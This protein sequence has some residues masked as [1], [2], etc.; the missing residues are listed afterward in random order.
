MIVEQDAV[1]KMPDDWPAAVGYPPWIAEVWM[2]YL[3]NGIKYSGNHRKGIPPTLIL[4]ADVIETSSVDGRKQV[5]FWIKDN[6]PGLS[7]DEIK[8]LFTP[9]ERLHNV[10][11][12]GHGLGLSIVQRIVQKLDG[13]VGV[14]SEPG[15]G[16]TFS[17]TLPAYVDKQLII[18]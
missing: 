7:Q 9:F 11:T 3:S 6:G 1:I 8:Q 13:E 15:E 2:N 18:Y 10:D 14:E 4:G 16:S 5:R 17:F 12:E